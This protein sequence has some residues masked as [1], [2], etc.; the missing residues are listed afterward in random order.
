MAA[1]GVDNWRPLGPAGLWSAAAV[2]RTA[3][4]L[5]IWAR[6]AGPPDWDPER[7][8]QWAHIIADLGPEEKK[9]RIAYELERAGRA[10]RWQRMIDQQVRA[11][12]KGAR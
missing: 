10:A 9:R 11:A 8:G 5:A 4:A 6:K 12:S 2:V 3:K 1:S 7:H